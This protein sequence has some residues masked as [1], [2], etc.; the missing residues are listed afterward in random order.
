M[1]LG[2]ILLAG[3]TVL[4]SSGTELRLEPILAAFREPVLE[5]VKPDARVFRFIYLPPFS[6][7]RRFMVRVCPGGGFHFVSM[8]NEGVKVAE[9]LRARGITAFVLKYRVLQTTPEHMGRVVAESVKHIDEEMAPVFPLAMADARTALG[10]VRGHA[11]EFG[12]LPTRL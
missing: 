7:M 3:V 9:W 6:S 2:V 10:Y 12:I 11:I 5:G 8:E 4:P 1:M